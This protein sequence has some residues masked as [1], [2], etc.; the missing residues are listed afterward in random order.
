LF[1]WCQQNPF[2]PRSRAASTLLEQS[3][4]S[5]ASCIQAGHLQKK[6]KLNHQ[7]RKQ[8]QTGVSFTVKCHKSNPF[9]CPTD[10][11]VIPSNSGGKAKFVQCS[12]KNFCIL[13]PIP[14]FNICAFT[15]N[16]L[17]S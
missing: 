3:D 9:F 17:E 5:H 8:M 4:E 13:F 10:D 6:D 16:R 14:D 7:S 15:L 11:A 12:C 2:A 1:Q